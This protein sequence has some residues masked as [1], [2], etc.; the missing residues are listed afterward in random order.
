MDI[1]H[2]EKRITG[3][4]GLKHGKPQTGFANKQNGGVAGPDEQ[5]LSRLVSQLRT[6][7]CQLKG[8]PTDY[9]PALR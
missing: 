5:Q 9:G 8:N 7:F 1:F 4:E 2:F 6:P 3:E